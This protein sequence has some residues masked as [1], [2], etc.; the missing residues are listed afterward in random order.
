[1]VINDGADDVDD[2]DLHLLLDVPQL[3]FELLCL[4]LIGCLDVLKVGNPGLSTGRLVGELLHLLLD[5]VHR[6]GLVIGGGF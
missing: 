1:M 3:L 4:K 6:A 2:A 5:R